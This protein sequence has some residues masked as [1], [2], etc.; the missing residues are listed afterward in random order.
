MAM[1]E[2][3]RDGRRVA[4]AAAAARQM[5]L[6]RL[7][8]AAWATVSLFSNLIAALHFQSTHWTATITRGPTLLAFHWVLLGTAVLQL[9][10]VGFLPSSYGPR[11]RTAFTLLQRALRLAAFM[12]ACENAELLASLP[13]ALLVAAEGMAPVPAVIKVCLSPLRVRLACCVFSMGCGE[14]AVGW[15]CA[16]PRARCRP[17]AWTWAVRLG[18]WGPQAVQQQAV[19]THPTVLWYRVV[20]LT[21]SASHP[22]A[23]GVRCSCIVVI[24]VVQALILHPTGEDRGGRAAGWHMPCSVARAVYWC[25]H[26]VVVWSGG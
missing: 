15:R 24:M 14:G 1:V 21:T 10:W 19:H 12:S 11:R 18:S 4:A 6:W 25:G 13:P 8:D 2:A 9:A 26:A 7:H 16:L 23:P 5:S 20:P 17:C 22:R 3:G